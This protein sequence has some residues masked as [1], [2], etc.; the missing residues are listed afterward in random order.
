[1]EAVYCSNENQ[2][3]VWPSPAWKAAFRT[4]MTAQ[5]AQRVKNHAAKLLR[6]LDGLICTS[7]AEDLVHD[8][9]VATTQGSSTWRPDRVG[10]RRH[11]AD[12]VEASLD[13][14]RERVARTESLE[15]R[16]EPEADAPDEEDHEST[17]FERAHASVIPEVAAAID[18]RS[19]AREAEAEVWRRFARDQEV[20]A[21]LN[22]F[23]VEVTDNPTIATMTRRSVAEVAAIRKRIARGLDDLPNSLQR[24][25]RSLLS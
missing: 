6:G 4:Q 13:R 19:V 3:I 20:M 15:A 1:M 9:I 18:L 11:L 14:L 22:C 7:A 17:D 10:L 24:R 25:V 5:A 8:A 21:V 23:A 2:P 16:I 12:H